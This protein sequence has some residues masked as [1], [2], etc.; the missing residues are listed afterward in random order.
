MYVPW[1]NNFFQVISITRLVCQGEEEQAKKELKP[2]T[3]T[4]L[5]STRF[6]CSLQVFHVSAMFHRYTS[7]PIVWAY[8]FLF[9]VK[10]TL[11]QVSA[12]S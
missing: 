5:N 4:F 7:R 3:N 6:C 12:T 11:V 1:Y 9:V 8:L 2:R 10:N